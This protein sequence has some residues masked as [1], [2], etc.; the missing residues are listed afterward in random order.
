MDL[1]ARTPRV[2]LKVITP[3]ATAPLPSVPSVPNWLQN[4]PLDALPGARG[5]VT[6]S[7]GA[8]STILV[9]ALYATSLLLQA[10]PP[11]AAVAL[12]GTLTFFDEMALPLGLSVWLSAETLHYLVSMAST[13]Q[14]PQQHESDESASAEERLATWSK[15]LADKTSNPEDLITGWFYHKSTAQNGAQDAVRLEELRDGNVKEW[16]AWSLG[17]GEASPSAN[18]DLTKSSD[19]HQ[20]FAMLEAALSNH[21]GRPFGFRRGYDE[22]IASM[23]LNSD[24]PARNIRPR[25]LLYYAVTDGII[26][27]LV[28]PHKM[29]ALGYSYHVADGLSYWYHPSKPEYKRRATLDTAARGH[30]PISGASTAPHASRTPLVFVHGV[31]IGPLP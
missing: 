15:C 2:T 10:M 30:G 25:P 26:G 8:K 9:K 4:V 5:A 1:F 14:R 24:P 3:T 27:G 7:D 28:T 18:I 17:I 31:G 16:L 23:R 12:V 13:S 21:L 6:S 22:R 29:R 11:A 20:A 19:L